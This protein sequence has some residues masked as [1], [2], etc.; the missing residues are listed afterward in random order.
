MPL[1]GEFLSEVRHGW[2]LSSRKD[3][4]VH[5]AA[6]VPLTT[7]CKADG[8]DQHHSVVFQEVVA[9]VKICLVAVSTYVLEDAY[10]VNA[11]ELLPLHAAIVLQP[12]VDARMPKVLLG[13][14]VLILR[15]GHACD[16][17]TILLCHQAREG[18]KATPKFQDP[19]ARLQVQ[20]RGDHVHLCQL[21]LIQREVRGVVVGAR[22]LHRGPQHLLVELR[23]DVVVR[24]DVVLG[25]RG[26]V[27]RQQ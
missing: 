17:H 24:R 12:N 20:F 3:V 5:E 6:M 10:G 22:V 8:V 18:S 19:H 21:R 25:A 15:E 7:P 4:L 14:G 9:L 27:T 2:Q 23:G 16:M 1:V 13:V 11:V 26:I